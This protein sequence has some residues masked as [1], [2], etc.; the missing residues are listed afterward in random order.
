MDHK[1]G[2]GLRHGH[3]TDVKGRQEVLAD[4]SGELQVT[5][6]HAREYLQ[7]RHEYYMNI[8]SSSPI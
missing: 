2:L 3:R 4:E 8:M 1:S 5:K 7:V 6:E